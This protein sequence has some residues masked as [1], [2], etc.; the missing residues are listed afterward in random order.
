MNPG[1]NPAH[2]SQHD[3]H[4]QWSHWYKQILATV[5]PETHIRSLVVTWGGYCHSCG[6]Q[7]ISLFSLLFTNVHYVPKLQAGLQYLPNLL[8][9]PFFL[10]VFYHNVWTILSQY[11][12]YTGAGPWLSSCKPGPSDL[13]WLSSVCWKDFILHKICIWWLLLSSSIAHSYAAKD[14]SLKI[15]YLS[16]IFI[17]S[18]ILNICKYVY[19]W[20]YFLKSILL[21]IYTSFD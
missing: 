6:S 10:H 11:L 14:H 21:K 2:F 7:A 18:K 20:K 13:C 1:D 19:F 8:Y 4:W 9:L 12:K 16:N 3:T 5:G 17:F 15:N